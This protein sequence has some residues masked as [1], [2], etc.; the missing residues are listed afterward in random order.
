MANVNVKSHT[1]EGKSTDHRYSDACPGR[2]YAAAM[3]KL[4]FAKL[5]VEFDFKLVDGEE[6]PKN[7]S[8]G[9]MILCKPDASLM[10]RRR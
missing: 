8:F 6:R 4:T 3:L 10:F 1:P 7:S 9:S 5:L 2:F